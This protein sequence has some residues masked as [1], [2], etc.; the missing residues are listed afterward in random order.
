L[1]FSFIKDEKLREEV[2]EDLEKC[3]EDNEGD[4]YDFHECVGEVVRHDYEEDLKYNEMVQI[5][6]LIS[7]SS[8]GDE[9]RYLRGSKHI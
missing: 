4:S 2:V 8:I 1:D 7:A 9:R 5:L 3:L 6:D